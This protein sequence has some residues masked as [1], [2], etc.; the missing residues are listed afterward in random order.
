MWKNFLL[1]AVCVVL[2]GCA[3]IGTS[4]LHA[5]RSNVAPTGKAGSNPPQKAPSA[6]ASARK[7]TPQQSFALRR[8]HFRHFGRRRAAAPEL[9]ATTAT[10][11][12]SNRS[13]R[14]ENSSPGSVGGVTGKGLLRVAERGYATPTPPSPPL[15]DRSHHL[16]RP[17]RWRHRGLAAKL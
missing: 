14:R 6:F 10:G 4:G 1:I 8:A 17:A 3:G 11:I 12:A 13:A 5:A 7:S 9:L 15:T 16:L 2:P